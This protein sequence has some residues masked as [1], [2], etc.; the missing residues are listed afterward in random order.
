M[1]LFGYVTVFA[2]NIR[3]YERTIWRQ[4]R[5]GRGGPQCEAHAHS[6]IGGLT[7]KARHRYGPAIGRGGPSLVGPCCHGPIGGRR[8]PPPP[9][10]VVPP[11]GSDVAVLP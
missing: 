1:R 2:N 9:S 5:W 6:G 3:D 11:Q 8:G 7:V 10:V 4:A